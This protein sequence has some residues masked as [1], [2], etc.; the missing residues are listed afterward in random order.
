MLAQMQD[1]RRGD[2]YGNRRE[3][4]EDSAPDPSW[5]V[6]LR[7]IGT[8]P[9]LFC[10]CAGRGDPFEYRDFAEALPEDQPVYAFGLPGWRA[11]TTVESLAADCLTEMRRIQPSGPYYL[12]GHSL[13]GLIVYEI[14]RTLE[15]EGTEPGLVA[16]FD[17]EHPAL[18]G[19]MPKEQR[20]AYRQ[21]YYRDRVAK[22]WSNLQ[23]GRL[24]RIFAD[25][26]RLLSTKLKRLWWRGSRWF[27]LLLGRPVP[28][29]FGSD[30]LHL[31]AAWR[32]YNPGGYGGRFVLFYAA[33]RTVEYSIDKFLGWKVCVSGPLDRI[34]VPGDHYTM[35]HPPFVASLAAEL[36]PF[37]G[38]ATATGGG[39]T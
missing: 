12:C 36:T 8:K 32:L 24:D 25:L 7:A 9:P 18:T 5:V 29:N 10:P 37:L 3:R 22:Y 2:E 11:E 13:G 15:R 34:V 30:A 31:S 21:T 17:T 20:A 4:T 1:V 16:V 26:W 28:R 23:H 6:P 19:I 39:D 38:S 14:A 27:F 33:E 35:L